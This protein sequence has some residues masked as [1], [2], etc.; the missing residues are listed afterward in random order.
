MAYSWRVALST[1]GKSD[2]TDSCASD[3]ASRAPVFRQVE[4]CSSRLRSGKKARKASWEFAGLL[5]LT[6]ITRRRDLLAEL[7]REP[8]RAKCSWCRGSRAAS[9]HP[10]VRRA[11]VPLVRKV[12]SCS[13]EVAAFR[14]DLTVF[15]TRPACGPTTVAWY[16][17]RRP[18]RVN[19]AELGQSKHVGA[20]WR[21]CGSEREGASTCPFWPAIRREGGPIPR[22]P[23]DAV[24]HDTP[25]LSS[26][27]CAAAT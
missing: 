17:L 4:P 20:L 10:C 12:R 26:S 19:R 24:C 13:R 6:G 14:V 9:A 16:S 11:N 3:L 18:G 5:Y 2:G 15:L 25:R 1:L 23:L 8:T 7:R 22:A 27:S 21:R